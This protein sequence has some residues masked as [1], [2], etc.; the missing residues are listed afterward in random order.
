MKT[1]PI[2]QSNRTPLCD[3]ATYKA[4]YAQ[5]INDSDVFWAEQ[6]KVFLD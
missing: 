3:E 6:A 2:A 1:Y 4:M 5:S